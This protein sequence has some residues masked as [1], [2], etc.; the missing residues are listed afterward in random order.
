MATILKPDKVVKVK[1][2]DQE[3]TI[4]QK[5]IPDSLTATKYN[6]SWCQTGWKMKPCRKLS[7]S[8]ATLNNGTGKPKAITV[9]NTNDISVAAGTNA[10]EQYTRATYGEHMSGV[11]VHFYVWH[12]D[13][14]QNLDETEQ[15]WHAAD[16]STRRKDHRGGQT[17]GNIDTIAIECIGADAESEDTVAK[18]VAYLCKKHGLDPKYDVYTHNY[19]MYGEDKSFSGVRKNCPIYILPHWKQFLEKVKGYYN[20]KAETESKK[21][22]YKVQCGAFAVKGNASNLKT[23]LVKEGFDDAYIVSINGLYKVQVGAFSVKE[24][25]VK[26]QE[27]LKD[28]G[29]KTFIVQQ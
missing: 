1:I 15:G 25:A 23:K 21:T 11:V 20:A 22:I 13:I 26:L 5:I 8:T 16:G 4:N 29:Y 24:N 14:W 9:H 17:G 19:W 10:A 27:K 6:A 18:L 28:K 3:L 2:G 12:D 7:P